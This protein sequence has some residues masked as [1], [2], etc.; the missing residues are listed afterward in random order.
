MPNFGAKV[1]LMAGLV[2]HNDSFVLFWAVPCFYALDYWPSA[3]LK[4]F[5]EHAAVHKWKKADSCVPRLTQLYVACPALR[6][7]ARVCWLLLER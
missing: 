4:G 7:I 2:C 5:K 1:P 3:A 6:N